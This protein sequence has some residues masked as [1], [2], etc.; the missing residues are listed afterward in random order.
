[1]TTTKVKKT[2]LRMCVVCKTMRPKSELIRI[3]RAPDGGMSFD[4]TGKANG[5]GAY[6]CDNTECVTKCLKKKILNKAFK[7][8]IDGEI[9]RKLAE[10]YAPEQN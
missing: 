6:L 2:P 8:N 4:R 5:R 10:E 3:V 9:Y 7:E 1:M